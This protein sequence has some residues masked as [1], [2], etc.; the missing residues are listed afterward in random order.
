MS[1]HQIFVHVGGGTAGEREKSKTL[2]RSMLV[3]V[4]KNLPTLKGMGVSIRIIKLT[5]TA[6]SNPGIV[7]QLEKALASDEPISFPALL[8][9]TR[10]Y[11]GLKA[12]V[13]LYERNLA[14]FAAHQRKGTGRPSSRVDDDDEEDELANFYRKEM[15]EE[16][17]LNDQEDDDVTESQDL[18][19]AYRKRMEERANGTK[20]KKKAPPKKPR[21][22]VAK[23]SPSRPN[24]LVRAREDDLDNPLASL[25][26]LRRDRSEDGEVDDFMLQSFLENM[27]E[28]T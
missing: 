21:P 26:A 1:K 24:N 20:D 16:K 5:D 14:G 23:T 27:E 7:R 13:S 25:K 4:Q 17:A 11:F 28:S 9:P 8:T 15:T 6:L 3:Y 18:M 19:A 22:P 2:T 12:I 10:P